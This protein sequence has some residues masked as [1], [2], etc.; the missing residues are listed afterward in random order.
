VFGAILAAFGIVALALA[1]AGIFGV[2]AFQVSRRGQE[3]GVRM[4]LGAQRPQ[5]LRDVLGQ[6][7]RLASIGI[8]VGVI[9]A[10]AAA[11]A[12]GSTLYGVHP[13]SP[14]RYGAVAALLMIATLVA[15]MGPAWRA[16]RV[17]PMRALRSD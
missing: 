13:G 7:G 1:V 17:D 6:A 16:S 3:I 8:G 2:L 5:V 14:W 11:R 10:V 12:L 4:A 15:A 9:G